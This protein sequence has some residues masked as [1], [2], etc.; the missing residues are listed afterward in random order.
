MRGGGEE[1][2]EREAGEGR[3]GER[4]VIFSLHVILPLSNTHVWSASLVMLNEEQTD[5][6]MA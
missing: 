6:D 1:S 5:G 2:D 3:E 4:C